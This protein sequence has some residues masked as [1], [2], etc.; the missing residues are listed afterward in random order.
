MHVKAVL[1]L[2][3][4]VYDKFF[5]SFSFG[6]T[7]NRQVLS[8]RNYLNIFHFLVKAKFLEST[9]K[10]SVL[11]QIFWQKE[12]KISQRKMLSYNQNLD[13]WF[14]YQKLKNSF[15][16][17]II[18]IVVPVNFVLLC[19]KLN[20]KVSHLLNL[21]ILNLNISLF[22][23]YVQKMSNSS[24]NQPNYIFSWRNMKN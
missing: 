7:L 18:S 23:P 5:N 11:N 21:R 14:I 3:K 16:F 12:K 1:N 15:C 10:V 4:Q 24:L 2:K 20:R 9:V 19:L 17:Q 13:K 22:S 6:N 8:L